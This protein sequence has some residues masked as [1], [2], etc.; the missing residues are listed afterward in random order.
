MI[1]ALI[2]APLAAAPEF[3]DCDLNFIAFIGSDAY[4]FSPAHAGELGSVRLYTI[5][6][7]QR[8]AHEGR[9]G[10]ALWKLEIAPADAPGRAV[11]TLGG[12][13]RITTEGAAVA[14]YYWDGRDDEGNRVPP[15]KYRYT[16]V[17]RYLADV[18]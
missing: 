1:L 11:F 10:F 15:G 12:R 7:Y 16:F 9:F 13:S 2:A 18:L 4:Q 17:A 8:A 14:E 5:L 6:S 3:D